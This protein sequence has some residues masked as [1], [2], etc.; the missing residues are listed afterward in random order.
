RTSRL[1]DLEKRA[2]TGLYKS[3]QGIVPVVISR[4][5]PLLVIGNN[6]GTVELRQM[7]DG[8]EL[9]SAEHLDTMRALALHPD[10]TLLASA[11]AGGSIRLWRLRL[12]GE[13][14]ARQVA[15]WQAHRGGVGSLIWSSDG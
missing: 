6:A 1:W 14:E 8:R 9:G 2:E 11:D 5:P 15:L 7:P 13:F 12:T 4:Q 3:D 10:G